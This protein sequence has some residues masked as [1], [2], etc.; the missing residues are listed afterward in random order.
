M[1]IRTL[2]V[3][4]LLC[5][6]AVLHA[7]DR[8]EKAKAMVKEAIAYGKK[9][10]KDALLKEVNNGSGRFH[11]KSGDDIYV[12]IYDMQGLCL[13]MGYQ[14]Q[15][16]GTNRWTIKDPDGKFIV[17]EFAATVKAKGAGWVDYKFPNPKTNKV[18]EKTTYVEG[19]DG[20]IIGCGVYK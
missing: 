13:G 11:V 4:A 18:E 1:N 10:G 5:A 7:E 6:V 15:A 19:L 17:Q 8:R 2:L 16:V 20:W 14:A 9:N 12:F 3:P